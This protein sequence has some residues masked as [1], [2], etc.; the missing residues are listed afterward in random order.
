[1]PRWE[2]GPHN[3][4]SQAANIGRVPPPG[5]GTFFQPWRSR[6]HGT[7][8]PPPS[9]MDDGAVQNAPHFF[10]H[11]FICRN[12]SDVKTVYKPCAPHILYFLRP[13]SHRTRDAMRMQIG[14]QILWC[15]LRAVWTL[16]L[17]ST[18]PIC[19]A[20][21]CASCV[22]EALRREL[23]CYCCVLTTGTALL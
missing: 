19:F 13:N 14:M 22:D 20:S 23:V 10:V 11:G 6:F 3:W 4:E 2:D 17:T 18:G 7:A 5:Q 9:H 8:P 16:P 12:N 21:R 1:M 15:C